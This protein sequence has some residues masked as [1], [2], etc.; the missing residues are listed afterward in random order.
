VSLLASVFQT[1]LSVLSLCLRKIITN[2]HIFPQVHEE[3]SDKK[4]SKLNIYVSELILG[5]YEYTTEAYE[6]TPKN[7]GNLTV[8]KKFITV[9]PMF[10]RLLRSSPLGTI[11][12][13]IVKIYC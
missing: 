13:L 6:G 1:F 10:H 7:S 11:N 5:S 4:N 8:I 2:P 3:R 9:T 12:T